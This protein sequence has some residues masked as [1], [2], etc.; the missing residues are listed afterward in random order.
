MSKR[1][2]SVGVAFPADI[3]A[4]VDQ[5]AADRSMSRTELVCAAIRVGLPLMRIGIAV[6]TRR[7]LAI[8]EHTQLALSLLIERESP[9]DAAELLRLAFRNVDAHHG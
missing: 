4:E 8:L 7:T 5:L 3:L 1:T 2:Q 6:N 9:D